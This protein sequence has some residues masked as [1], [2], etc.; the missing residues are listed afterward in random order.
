MERDHL[1]LGTLGG[2]PTDLHWTIL[3]NFVWLYIWLGDLLATTIASI[4]L[5][6][7][8]AAHELGH[9]ALLRWRKVEVESVTLHGL[10]GRTAH[11]YT[12]HLDAG[13]GAWGG[14][15][16]QSLI[17]VLALVGQDLIPSTTAASTWIILGPIF[18]VLIKIN[19]CLILV[20]LLP[21][22]PFDGH[23]AW[24]GVPYI[25]K[26][27]RRKIS[28]PKE[29]PLSTEQLQAL[30]ERSRVEAADLLARISKKADS[31]RKDGP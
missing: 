8:F 1:K 14:V 30:E 7:L 23:K 11:E 16:A 29:R 24:R 25:V 22:G 6:A 13:I 20:A 19:F 31:T 18:L 10:H 15:L 5:L 27:M 2:V 17:L 26:A 21:I 9:I 12:S 4:T 28:Q 3:L